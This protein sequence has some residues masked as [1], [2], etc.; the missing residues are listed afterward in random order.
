M[1][2][3]IGIPFGRRGGIDPQAKAA[4]D[5]LIAAG[6]TCPQGL[7]GINAAFKT[8]KTIYSTSDITTAIS[9]FGDP[10][11]SYQIGTGSGTTLGQA[12]RTLPNLVD[13]TRAT[14]AVQTTAA[15]QPLLLLHS[16]EN[17]YQSVGVNGNFVSTPNV[18]I[19]TNSGMSVEC[20]VALIPSAAYS[21]NW[22]ISNDNGSS[23]RNLFL[24]F[25]SP[26]RSLII[27]W[28][29]L[30]RTAI[31]T[32]VLPD[33]FNGWIKAS[34]ESVGADM[35]VKFFTSAD[36]STYIQLGSTI[37]NAGGANTYQTT[38]ADFNISGNGGANTT[39]CKNFRTIY[40]DA[41]GVTRIDFNPNQYNPATSQTQWTSS[42]GE[43]WTINKS[44]GNTFTGVLVYQN[45]IQG[46]NTTTSLPATITLTQPAT[47]YL[48]A[49]RN[50]IGNFIE[51]A[52]GNSR[53]H[54]GTNAT[55]NN[56]TALNAA[57][58]NST[59]QVFTF[60]SNGANSGISINNGTETT[61]NAGTNNGTTLVLAQG[62]HNIKTVIQS[63]QNDTAPQRTAMFDY[64]K[65][66]SGI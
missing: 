17:Y 42:T 66:S 14:D 9:F 18:S 25:S 1:I 52:T 15:S 59:R 50:G 43:V 20:K 53:S 35:H 4:F 40:K 30:T 16:G 60:R 57:N 58:A 6:F 28:A 44:T 31:S 3:G 24:G 62:A 5:S 49:T 61:G 51:R 33:G 26:N 41:N 46:N 39:I 38:T 11:L 63:K 29:N 23:S 36:G 19:A 54:N 34:L 64:L 8:I 55:L 37:I 10:N 22:I 7:I 13:V 12:I 45:I 2:I 47:E 32:T 48:S 27:Y 56:G 21:A 65:L